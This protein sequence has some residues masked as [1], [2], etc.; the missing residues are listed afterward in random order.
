MMTD[1]RQTSTIGP[2]R[3]QLLTMTAA[4]GALAWLGPKLGW[5]ERAFAATPPAKPT[6]QA[7][8]GLSQEPTVFNP[9]L[10]HIEVDEAVYF[11]LF[12]ALWRVDPKGVFVPDL[13]SEIPTVENGGLSA[14]GLQWRIKLKPNVQWHDG[15]SFT[16]EDIK[17]NIELIQNPKFLAGRRAGHEL[18]RDIKVVSPTELTWRMDKAYAPYPAILSWTFFVPKH[19]IWSGWSSN[20]SRT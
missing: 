11:N 4:A 14:D 1:D 6:G 5:T 2:N 15:A 12:S 20:M 3:R 10:V 19:P 8:I 18:V 13:V 7:V 16:A 17:F 9:L